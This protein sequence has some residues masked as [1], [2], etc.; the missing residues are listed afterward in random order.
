[1]TRLTIVAAACICLTSS[2]AL[3]RP[4]PAWD[5]PAVLEIN[6][7][8]PHATMMTY[9]SAALARQG[10]RERSPWFLSL[11]GRWKFH[12]S[13]DPAGR[14]ADFHRPDFADT[15]WRTLPVPSNWQMHGYGIPI[16][17]NIL[18]P[19]PQD[20]MGP[21][22]VPRENNEVG[23]YRTVFTLPTEWAGRQTFLHF[24]GVDSAFYVWVNGKEVGYS[25]DS[26]TPAEF[27]ITRHLKPGANL[28][29]VEVYRYSDGAF[30][31]DQDMFRLSG[32]YRDVYLWSRA[33]LRIR[34]FETV[35]GLDS[36]LEEGNLRVKAAVANLGRTAAASTVT[37]ELF[38]AAGKPVFPARREKLEVAAGGEATL[39]V[40]IP[41]GMPFKWSAE[42]PYLYQLLLTL[43][44]AAGAV[45]EIIP[46]HV[47][48][49][50]VEIRDGVLLV[51]GRAI[52]FKGVNRH[53]HHP[54]TGHYVDRKTMLRDIELMKQFNINAVRTSH[55]PN[56]PEWYELCDRFGIYVWDEGNIESHHYGNHPKN[57][58][59]NDPAWRA[60]HLERVQRMVERDKNHPCVVVWSLGNESGDGPNA[61]AVY[62]WVRQR[63]PTRPFHYEGS[64]SNGG[65][66]SDI[67]SFM[68][69]HVRSLRE[70]AARRPGMPLILCEYAHSMG[71]SQGNL[72]EYWDVF[73][74]EPN[75][76]GAFVWDWVDQGIRQPVPAG[77]LAPS[78]PKTFLAYGGWWEDRNGV[79]NDG[80]FCQNGL[81]NADR[82]PYPGLWALKYV[83][84][85]L[86]AS[87]VDPAAGR[88]KVKSWFDFVNAKDVA[89][90]RWEVR[91]DGRAIASGSLPELDLAPRQE[92]EF[93]VAVP[94][95]RPAPGVEYWLNL[96]FLT[97]S[98]TPWAAK[99][100]EISWEQ[101]PLPLAAP[102]ARADMS[103]IPDLGFSDWPDQTHLTGP[104]FAVAFDKRLGVLHDYTFR[105]SLL[106]GRG[107]LP[108][109]WRAMTDNDR[110]A[111]KSLMRRAV[112][113]PAAD[114]AVWRTAASAWKITG[115][116]A[117]RL[118]AKSARITVKADLPAVAGR[119]TMSCTIYGSGDIVVD[120]AYEP[121]NAKLAMM[122]RF[123]TELV[124]AP[125]FENLS[126][127]GRGPADTYSD[128]N[129]ER[130][131]EYSTTVAA[132]WI[133]YSRPQE[134]GNKVDVRRLTLTDD[135]G[136]GLLAVG[137]PHLS[138]S[139]RHVTKADMEAPGYSMML[140][141]RAEIYLNLDAG[142]MGVGG[143]DSW[144]P[145]AYPLEAYRIPGNQVHRC[146][147]RLSPVDGDPAAKAR[148]AF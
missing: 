25:E 105:G 77:Y 124:V 115:V 18:Y 127:Y 23:S 116:E 113:D 94:A 64:T 119:Y 102:A 70:L 126:W 2:N 54:D 11:N 40:E 15:Q 135:K 80:N 141:R 93:F 100:H 103:A 39:D 146:R 106:L 36:R 68:Y 63:D 139:A 142:Q 89:E 57:R 14:P 90:G 131:G 51:N 35:A 19:W 28:L 66:N 128:R 136:R 111:W 47:G 85:S 123:G 4:H 61:A 41:A 147:Y 91:A 82:K 120:A 75:I 133:D 10:T 34:D 125:G 60:A 130:V 33:D 43:R 65:T 109:F 107:P 140:P 95:I 118:D 79:R 31:E 59:M 13:K 46:S 96:S 112:S 110:G 27:N 5:D 58:L 92:K 86:H 48:F 50:K 67:N 7:E 12:W 134:N 71:N 44:N 20:P 55:Y 1:M 52:R 32:I 3:C 129:Y 144:S 38:D 121:G 9:P 21:P 81:V 37:V 122:P 45:V 83:Y 76:Q 24:D 73:Y 22:V 108:D 132:S 98:A 17:T 145:N 53:E 88:I 69:P 29:A 6:R 101:F 49:R 56:A 42:T 117:V 137:M 78:G 148:T 72:K 16:Y 104:D 62:Q 8:K 26:R 99:G 84:R 74:A 143:T 138:A 30:L 97:K 87:A 114:I